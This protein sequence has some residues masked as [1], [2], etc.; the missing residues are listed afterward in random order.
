MADKEQEL[1]EELEAA[2]DEAERL[3][4]EKEA[5]ARELESK[6][7]AITGLEQVVAG[8]ESEILTLKE[9]VVASDQKMTDINADLSRAVA[10]YKAL[11]VAANPEIL[12][13]MITGETVEAINES[14]EGARALVDRVRQG[15]EAEVSRTKIPAGAPQ[16]APLDLSVLSPREKI[17]YAI[18][19]KR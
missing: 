16:R 12:V 4:Q 15:I 11:V 9:T 14:L 10:S 8:H 2:R 1:A 5:L 18:G 3:K 19:G 7:T 13:D 17:Q 6:N